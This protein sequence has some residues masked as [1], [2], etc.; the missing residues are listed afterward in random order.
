VLLRRLLDESGFNKLPH[1]KDYEIYSEHDQDGTVNFVLEI[2][3]DALNTRTRKLVDADKYPGAKANLQNAARKID[4]PR[5]ARN[6]VSRH[7]LAKDGSVHRVQGM[8]RRGKPAVNAAKPARDARKTS[9]HRDRPDARE[10]AGERQVKHARAAIA[11]RRLELDENN[12]VMM[13]KQKTVRNTKT[14]VIFPK[15]DYQGIMKKFIDG[16]MKII[17]E[18][19]TPEL[20]KLME[21]IYAV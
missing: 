17:E 3:T 1:L 13:E 4:N 14:K 9:V 12:E 2:N 10:T 21:K 5:E 8:R 16:I 20:S 6:Y 7:Y 18:S 15:E 19:F 11:P